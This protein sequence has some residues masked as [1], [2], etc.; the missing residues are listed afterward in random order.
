MCIWRICFTWF[1]CPRTFPDSPPK[2][3]WTIEPAPRT[4]DSRLAAIIERTYEGTLDCPQLNG[5]RD[6]HDV[7]AGYRACGKFDPA[8][9]LIARRGD[10]D[11]GCL[12][13]TDHPDEDQWE[14]VYA[15]LVPAERGHGAGLAL[16]EHAQFL[17]RQAGRARMVLAVDAAN[18]PAVTTY[19]RV[20]FV[21]WDRRSAQLRVFPRGG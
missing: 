4:D 12:L 6:V 17:T 5:V 18:A 13:L 15:G 10:C 21:T 14:L 7:L 8:R 11:V 20:G 2:S 1:A 9:W 3:A 16:A 19:E